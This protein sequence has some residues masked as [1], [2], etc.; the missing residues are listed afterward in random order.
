MAVPRNLV[1][2]A[3]RAVVDRAAVRQ[4]RRPSDGAGAF[5]EHCDPT[6]DADRVRGAAGVGARA[7]RTGGPAPGEPEESDGAAD[8]R[9]PVAGVQPHHLDGDPRPGPGAPSCDPTHVPATGHFEPVD[10]S[11]D[12]YHS[13]ASNS[14]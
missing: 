11:P 6:A 1:E 10:L 14:L 13:L 7:D 5:V 12:I 4:A 8:K 2:A 3:K 9:T